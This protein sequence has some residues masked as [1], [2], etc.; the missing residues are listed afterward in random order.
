MLSWE[1]VSEQTPS[2]KITELHLTG[3]IREELR[4]KTTV[5]RRQLTGEEL[6]QKSSLLLFVL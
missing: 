3:E 2:R 5:N 1:S 6:L 4:E